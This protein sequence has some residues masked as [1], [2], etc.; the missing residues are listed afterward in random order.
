M[1]FRA[2][3]RLNDSILINNNVG[4]ASLLRPKDYSKRISY[5]S[6]TSKRVKINYDDL[7]KQKNKKKFR[8]GRTTLAQYRSKTFFHTALDFIFTIYRDEIYFRFV[9]DSERSEANVMVLQ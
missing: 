5:S 2:R 7:R 3:R 6:Q 8:A 4:S 9:L 1:H